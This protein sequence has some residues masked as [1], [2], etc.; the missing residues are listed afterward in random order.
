MRIL[1][2]DI[3]CL[4]PDHLGCFGYG[5]NTSPNI[6]AIAARG[7]RFSNYY[8]TDAPC[9][10]SRTALFTGRTGIHTGVI[11]HGGLNAD[12]R[13]IGPDRGFNNY[14]GPFR[15]WMTTLVHAGL[16]TCTVSP[17]ATRHAAWHFLD[18]FKEVHDPGGRGHER[19]D[20]IAPLALDWLKAN[21]AKD[22]WFLHVNFWDP[23]T[24]YRTP[25]DYGNPFENDPAPLWLTEDILRA[26][27]E[28]YGPHSA[29]DLWEYGPYDTQK[30]PRAP[31]EIETL[32]D[33]RKWIDGYDTGI[34]YTDDHV[35]LILDELRTQGVLDDTII[36]VSADHG[37][38]QG[39][40][41]VYGDHQTADHCTSRVPLIAA[42]PGIVQGREDT[43]LHYNVDLAATICALAGGEQPESW[44]GT[45]FLPALTEGRS[46]GQPY[47]VVSQGAWSCQRSVRWKNW[48][49]VRTYNA[50]LKDFPETMLFDI[51]SDPH[52]TYNLASEREDVVLEGLDLLSQWHEEMMD[53]RPKESDPMWEVMREGG[54][55]QT[56]G[57][58]D[59]YCLVLADTGRA[60]AAQRMRDREERA[61]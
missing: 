29:R 22:N 14:A 52:E 5:R 10:P 55:F 16:H 51:E 26:Q 27:R 38:N 54:P 35:G 48:M 19:A 59:S 3:D 7:T 32:A 45:S 31:A 12:I 53:G 6:D 46:C 36:L 37:E 44:D 39:E 58:L 9:L 30:Y 34:R 28:S 23:H 13:P 50:G 2:I 18:G 49:M 4:R 60:E 61:G 8:V 25:L 20:E 56:R 40:L 57:Y 11:N 42:G 43:D 15:T 21:A 17:F 47:L 1:Y 41:N 24:P 33:F